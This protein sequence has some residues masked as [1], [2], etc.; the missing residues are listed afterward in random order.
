MYHHSLDGPQQGMFTHMR[1]GG[2]VL[3]AA[4]VIGLGLLLAAGFFLPW[5]IAAAIVTG[6]AGVTL[7]VSSARPTRTTNR[8]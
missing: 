5:V 4:A 8:P 3:I 6:L 7:V 1:V 2:V